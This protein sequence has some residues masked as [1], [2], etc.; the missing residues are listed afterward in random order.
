MK[1]T[2]TSEPEVNP[3]ALATVSAVAPATLAVPVVVV[4]GAPTLIW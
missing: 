4:D 3:V 1:S 2:T